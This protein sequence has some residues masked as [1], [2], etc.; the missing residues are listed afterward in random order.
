MPAISSNGITGTWA[1]AV[2][3]NQVSGTYT[4]TS[5][6]NECAIPT[7]TFTV[8]ITP[9]ATGTVRSDT[10]VYDGAM[11]PA[12]NFSGTPAGVNY[13]WSND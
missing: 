4:F 9:V 7:A 11:L 2:V 13:S 6:A 12:A 10:T 5:A 3:S 8:T 1:P